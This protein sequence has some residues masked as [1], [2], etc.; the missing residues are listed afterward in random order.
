MIET[1]L[2]QFHDGWKTHDIDAV[3]TLFR[4]D[5]EYWETPHR[6]LRGKEAVRNEW[7]LIVDQQDIKVEWRV[8]ASTPD[9]RH[10]VLWQLS[11]AQD[12]SRHSS[13]GV[14]LIKLDNAGLCEYFY[15]VGEEK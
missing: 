4:E 11:Y 7:Q 12:S 3:M 9:N 6:Q 2:Q 15:Y 10:S 13:A 14:Y 8:F 1:W 5:V